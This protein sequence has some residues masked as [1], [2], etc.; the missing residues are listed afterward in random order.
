M[1]LHHFQNFHLGLCLTPWD[2]KPEDVDSPGE[3]ERK[4]AALALT[5]PT[6]WPPN[7]GTPDHY[8][9]TRDRRGQYHTRRGW[10]ASC[11]LWRKAAK[12]SGA[13]GGKPASPLS[14]GWLD[15]H[16][17]S[18]GATIVFGLPRSSHRPLRLPRGQE[19]NGRRSPRWSV[20]ASWS[21]GYDRLASTAYMPVHST[22][23]SHRVLLQLY[24]RGQLS[25]GSRSPEL[26]LKLAQTRMY[27][28]AAKRWYN[29]SSIQSRSSSVEDDKRLRTKSVCATDSVR[30]VHSAHGTWKLPRGT[31][32]VRSGIDIDWKLFREGERSCGSGRLE[33]NAVEKHARGLAQGP[34]ALRA[35]YSKL[36]FP[37]APSSN[38]DIDY[39]A[40]IP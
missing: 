4:I 37:T 23:S 31:T 30:D 17:S 22:S 28:S 1:P 24:A 7:D 13:G 35:S 6:L 26:A 11:V 16:A 38:N 21:S 20:G 15:K 8:Q 40:T 25:V 3:E 12:A 32:G 29:A 34:Q 27:T 36:G 10:A 33:G 14:V 5:G 18:R 19:S 39:A 9:T 2:D